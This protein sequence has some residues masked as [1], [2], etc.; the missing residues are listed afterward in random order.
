MC[1]PIH[2]L[3]IALLKIHAAIR[4]KSLLLEDPDQTIV[5]PSGWTE[6]WRLPTHLPDSN[7]DHRHAIAHAQTLNV[8]KGDSYRV[9]LCLGLEARRKALFRQRFITTQ[10][11]LSAVGYS[12]SH[13]QIKEI[14]IVFTIATSLSI[15]G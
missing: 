14:S 2:I 7:G 5:L 4:T 10:K 11:L 12:F 3:S 15:L 6:S 8:L 1:T 13:P 9:F